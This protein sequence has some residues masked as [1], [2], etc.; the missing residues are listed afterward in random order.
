[1]ADK[2]IYFI[3]QVGYLTS[4]PKALVDDE[5]ISHALPIKYRAMNF[6][7]FW[8]PKRQRNGVFNFKSL[9]LPLWTLKYPIIHGS[10]FI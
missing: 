2:W 10:I 3:K 6:N 7:V 4:I 5:T 8:S 9:T 1:M